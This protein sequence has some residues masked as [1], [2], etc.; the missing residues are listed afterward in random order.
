MFAARLL[1]VCFAAPGLAGT[2]GPRMD[3]QERA[4]VLGELAGLCF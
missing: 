4:G 1:T 2:T 3:L